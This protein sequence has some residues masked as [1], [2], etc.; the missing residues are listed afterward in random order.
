M[1]GAF[2]MT[3]F[4]V[5]SREGHVETCRRLGPKPAW[6]V[7]EADEVL[8]DEV[9]EGLLDGLRTLATLCDGRSKLKDEVLKK[10]QQAVAL[11]RW[12]CIE[13]EL[14]LLISLYGGNADFS[15]LL[16]K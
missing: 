10:V 4:G 12:D 9:V 14:T 7:D 2:S 15:Q 1:G 13:G 5:F 3:P 11:A 8:S 6:E 16:T